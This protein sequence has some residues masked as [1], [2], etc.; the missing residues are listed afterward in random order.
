MTDEVGVVGAGPGGAAA[1]LALA[2]AGA[3]VTLYRPAR[4]GEKPCGGAIPDAFLPAIDGFDP[5]ARA[6]PSVEPRRLVLE[7]AAG[8]CVE[9]ESPGLRVFRRADFDAALARAA[10]A[11]GAKLVAS[12]VEAVDFAPDGVEVRAGGARRRHAY[13]VAADGARGLVRRSLALAPGAESVGLGASLGG[14]VPDRLAL[15]FPDLADAYCWVFPRPG[16]ASVGI[17]YDAARLSHGAARAALDRFLDRHLDGG[18]SSLDHARRYRYPIPIWSAAT[19]AAA[20]Q[21]L[22]ARVLLVGDAAGVAD[23]LTREGIRYALLSG[24]W[25]AESLLAGAG[26]SYPDR[27]DDGLAPELARAGRAARLFYDEP[28]AQWMV[29][30]ARRHPGIRSVLGDLLT[31]RQTYR[32]LRRTLLRAAVGRYALP[33]Q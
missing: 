19:R 14:P 6:A 16:G 3:G 20:Q 33:R 5:T 27:L 22:R 25:A 24:R 17:A 31:C 8:S 30:M 13:V 32:G 7:N 23:P 29:P 15:G 11:A 26:E 28:L 4:M 12:R 10:V 9:V 1:A 2:R 18:R 21:A